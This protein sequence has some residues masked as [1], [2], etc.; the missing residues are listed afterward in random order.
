MLNSIDLEHKKHDIEKQIF[1]F[2]LTAVD[3]LKQ[4]ENPES[5]KLKNFD[6]VLLNKV[7][8]FDQIQSCLPILDRSNNEEKIN[9][10][11]LFDKITILNSFI[12]QEKVSCWSSNNI[13]VSDRWIEIFNF[14]T[15]NNYTF[16]NILSMVEYS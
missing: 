3:Y 5:E 16:E 13:S 15:E 4:W 9:E 11:D 10:N 12:T 7:P 14:L 1:E 6:W 8:V 2:Y